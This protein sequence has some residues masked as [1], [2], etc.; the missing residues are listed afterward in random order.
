MKKRWFRTIT[1][2]LTI[3]LSMTLMASATDTTDDLEAAQGVLQSQDVYVVGYSPDHSPFSYETTDGTVSGMAIDMMDYIAT[4]AGIAVEYVSLAEQTDV[5]ISLSILDADQRTDNATR[6]IPY[7]NFQMILTGTEDTFDVTGANIGHLNY[8]A[9][10][11]AMIE[12]G[13]SGSTAYTYDSYSNMATALQAGD[14]DYILTST[15]VVTQTNSLRQSLGAYSHETSITL[16]LMLKYNSTLSPEV[17]D[18]FNTVISHLDQESKYNIMLNAAVT[19]AAEELTLRDILYQNRTELGCLALLLLC[20]GTFLVLHYRSDKRKLLLD[21]LYVDDL[22]GLMTERKFFEVLETKL[23][24]ARKPYYIISLDIDNFKYIN[25]NY[26]YEQGTQC[27]ISFGE[28]LCHSFFHA[29]ALARPFADNFLVLTTVAPTIDNICG[30]EVCRHCMDTCLT[31]VLGSDY[32]LM[33]SAGI[34]KV[35]P[36]STIHDLSY[37]VD[38]ANIARRRGKDAYARSQVFFTKEIEE[39][40]KTKNEIIA[41]MEQAIS[42]REFKMHYQ[43]KID[44]KTNQVIGAEALVRWYTPNGN[45]VYPNQF[46]YL[47]EQN[48]FITRLDFYVLDAVCQ[49]LKK[50]PK[51]PKISVNISGFSF[52]DPNLISSIMS[53]MERNQIDT[54]RIEIEITESAIVNEFDIIVK[55]IEALQACGFTVSMDDFGAGMSSLHRLKDISIDVLKIDKEFLGNETLSEKGVSII[56]GIIQMSHRIGIATVAEGVETA[57]QVALLTN[58]ACNV[59]QGYY[60]SRPLEEEAFVAFVATKRPDPT[61]Q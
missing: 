36:N 10:D 57:E 35:E 56:D 59:A 29:E 17:M 42:Q 46:I 6:S 19:A 58:L 23:K 27:I 55:K 34:Y 50:H 44:F 39:E 40:L 22:T 21:T 49:F 48:G 8:S 47:F 2:F 4:T 61:A 28:M 15:L 26:S 14:I 18:A 38:C 11:D 37:M 45:Q 60:Y 24:K 43:P 16:D 9:I 25:E 51:M 1:W 54:H 33:I 32:K 53:I 31:H 41:S 12:A 5:D 13:L 52:L 20:L 3:A 7:F 30:R